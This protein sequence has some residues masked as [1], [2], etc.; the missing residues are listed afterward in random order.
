MDNQKNELE[1][2]F[3]D[4]DYDQS[5]LQQWFQ[6]QYGNDWHLMWNRYLDTGRIFL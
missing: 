5:Q 4:P 2:L 1:E 6:H 3:S